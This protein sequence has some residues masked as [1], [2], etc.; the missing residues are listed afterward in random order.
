[1]CFL[2]LVCH[3]SASGISLAAPGN[4]TSAQPD[5]ANNR[6][7]IM[8]AY[9]RIRGVIDWK[10]K[11]RVYV[12]PA[13]EDTIYAFD[14]EDLKT[15]TKSEKPRF[16]TNMALIQVGDRVFGYAEEEGAT[17]LWNEFNP[18]QGCRNKLWKMYEWKLDG[19]LAPSHTEKGWIQLG[20]VRGY[21]A[22]EMGGWGDERTEH[23]DIMD[24]PRVKKA[25]QGTRY[26]A[27]AWLQDRRG[28]SLHTKGDGKARTR[29][30]TCTE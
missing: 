20:R 9:G 28:V 26:D 16:P 7:T 13:Q 21:R 5:P 8:G 27:E 12:K 17:Y 24:F 18:D 4:R 29:A 19:T 1:M 15:W 22:Q 30:S 6:F 10:G 14:S 11:T 3:L 2:A 23:P 25:F